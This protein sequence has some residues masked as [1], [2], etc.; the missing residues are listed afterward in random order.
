MLVDAILSRMYIVY[1]QKTMRPAPI[2]QIDLSSQSPAYEQIAAE[3]RALLV[4]GD[5][6]PGAALP[7]VRQLAM[8]LNVHH[9]TVASAY[10]ILAAEGWLDL[11]RRRGVRVVPR[12]KAPK[13]MP[14]RNANDTFHRELTRLLAKAAADGISPS[15]LVRHLVICARQVKAWSASKGTL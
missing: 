13:H 11:R 10:R 2:I 8:D 4:S 1:V 5:L 7:T 6:A 15:A 12:T 3:I 9:N 14:G